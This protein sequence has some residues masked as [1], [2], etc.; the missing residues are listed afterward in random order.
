M[1]TTALTAVIALAG[2]PTWYIE[3]VVAWMTRAPM[4]L[5]EQREPAAGRRAACRR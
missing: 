1:T 2:T 3:V 4:T 5:P